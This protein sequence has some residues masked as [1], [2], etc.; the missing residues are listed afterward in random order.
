M[1]TPTRLVVRGLAAFALAAAVSPLRGQ[2]AVTSPNGRNKVTITVTEGRLYYSLERDRRQLILPSLLGCEFRGAVPLRDGL[3]V[4]DTVRQSHDEW[5]TQPWGE[6]TRVHDHYNELAVGVEET[7]PPNRRFT[8][9]VRSFDDG[10]GFRYEFPSQ[11]GLAAFEISNELTEF[12]LADNARA[13]WIPSN[14]PRKDRS[15]E[16]YSSGPVSTLDSVQTPLTMEMRDGRTFMV[17]H[18]ANL[19]HYARMFLAGPRME[20][21]TLRAALA[22]LADGIKVRGSTPFVTPWRTIQLADRATELAPSLLGLNLNPPNVLA[23]TD[24]IHPMKFVGIWWGMH[25]GTMTWASGPKHGATT[26]NARR[27]IDFAA[28]NGIGGVLVEGWNTGWDGDWIANRDAFSFTKSYP[29][30]DLPAVAAYARQKGVRLIVHNETSGGIEN[31][32]RQMDTAF[33][34][35]RSLGL[36]AIKSGYVTDLTSAGDSHYSQTMVEH[37]RRVIELAA[38]DGIMLDVHEPMHDTG[39]RRTYPNMMS[40]EGSRGQEYNA[41]SGDGGNPPEHES[42]LF[43][44]RM[45]AGPMDF[46]PGIFDLMLQRSTGRPRRLDEPRPR[47]TLAKQLA[48][49]VVLYSPLQM[50][51]DLPENYVAQPA[52][53]FIRDVAVDWDTTRVLDG[54]IGDYVAVARRERGGQSWYLGAITD[55]SARTLDVPLSF[56]TPGKR[57]VAEVYADG[58][59][60]NWYD[61]PLPVTITRRTV[62]STTQLHIAMAPGGGQAIRIRPA[63]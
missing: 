36:D 54:R 53:Q 44:T 19:V 15:E 58:P 7:A 28:A 57:Y 13:W 56:L 3:R 41:W 49:Y 5:W 52:F 61:N 11:P 25:I 27:Y 20:G 39:E 37:Y 14:W 22:P 6:V 4:T 24:W 40:R 55:E 12:A 29:D 23:S 48:L 9:R 43:F 63:R 31:Y 50:A 21:R 33:A 38:R 46:T 30:Y 59:G 32:E 47:T 34:L 26:A 45:L 62:T 17:I 42:I 10:V 18:E 35:Y 2:S 1:T 16:L 60:A 8:V 51:A